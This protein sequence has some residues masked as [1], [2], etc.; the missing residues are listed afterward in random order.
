MRWP[1]PCWHGFLNVPGSPLSVLGAPL[2][3]AKK[4]KTAQAVMRRRICTG[5]PSFG[6]ARGTSWYGI[7]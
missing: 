5:R 3:W 6:T 2:W 4:G 7:R 1:C